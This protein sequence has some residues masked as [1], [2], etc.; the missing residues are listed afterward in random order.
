MILKNALHR[1]KLFRNNLRL[2]WRHDVLI[3]KAVTVKYPDTLD[4]GAK[5]TLQ[6]NVYIYGSKTGRKS[7]IGSH[8]VIGSGCMLFGE[9]G[10]TIGDS[11]HLGP[12]VVATTQYG[13]SASDLLAEIPT[14]K[15]EEIRI[16]KGCWIGS[17]SIIMPGTVLGDRCIVAPNSVVY[18]TW[19]DGVKLMGNP[20]RR[21][22]LQ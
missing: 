13:D 4:F 10:I 6:S 18:G 21:T 14:L 22:A 19:Q 20:A 16:G 9:G 2:S 8:V 7:S 3:E 12:N 1:L 11:T 15:V 17:G 5:C